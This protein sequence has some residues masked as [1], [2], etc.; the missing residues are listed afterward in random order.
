[1]NQNDYFRENM[2][3]QRQKTVKQYTKFISG[4]IAQKYKKQGSRFIC[5]FQNYIPWD[6]EI[7]RENES[8]D[9]VKI[10]IS[11][12]VPFPYGMVQ[13]KSK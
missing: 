8:G 2:K 6:D 5:V 1:M 10:D 3:K 13:P 4:Y 11:K 12:E 9:R 7:C